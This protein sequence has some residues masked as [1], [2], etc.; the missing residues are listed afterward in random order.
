MVVILRKFLCLSGGFGE[1]LDLTLIIFSIIGA[2]LRVVDED[3][4]DQ[5]FIVQHASKPA[6]SCKASRDSE[7]GCGREGGLDAQRVS[8]VDLCLS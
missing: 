2:S 7:S 6:R 4:S 5:V 1:E 8:G 3:C